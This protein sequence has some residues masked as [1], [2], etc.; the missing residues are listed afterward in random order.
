MLEWPSA[1]AA[2]AEQNRGDVMTMMKLSL[3]VSVCWLVVLML[4]IGIAPFLLV[5]DLQPAR[6]AEL[7]LIY[8]VS[9]SEL[10]RMFAMSMIGALISFGFVASTAWNSIGLSAFI[11]E[12]R[13]LA[14]ISAPPERAAKDLRELEAKAETAWGNIAAHASDARLRNKLVVLDLVDE[15]NNADVAVDRYRAITARLKILVAS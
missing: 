9:P 7:K 1:F 14:K 4:S 12:L 13:F 3:Y 5:A 8:T 6:I 11:Q 10:L 2:S 15:A